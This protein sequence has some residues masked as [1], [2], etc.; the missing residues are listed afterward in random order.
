MTINE[1]IAEQRANKLISLGYFEKEYGFEYADSRHP[2]LDKE[3]G[4]YYRKVPLSVTDAQFDEIVKIGA[5]QAQKSKMLPKVLM[6]TG[7]AIYLISFSVGII[8]GNDR[9]YSFNF[10][11]MLAWWAGGFLAGTQFLWMAEVLKELQRR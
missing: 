7:I 9:Y 10:G 3:T 8:E 1:R 5:V 4:K 6:W 2:F 11:T